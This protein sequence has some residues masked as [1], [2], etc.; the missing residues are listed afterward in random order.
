MA[1]PIV[2]GKQ[3][4]WRPGSISMFTTHAYFHR[5]N[6]TVAK[7]LNYSLETISNP[8]GL[9]ITKTYSAATHELQGSE[10]IIL[11]I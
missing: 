2:A 1:A 7:A 4:W 9:C 11:K 6:F 5:S 3:T 10:I 8:S